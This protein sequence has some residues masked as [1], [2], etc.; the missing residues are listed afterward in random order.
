MPF[1]LAGF[2]IKNILGTGSGPSA[3]A[4]LQEDGF[5]ILQEDGTS[6]ILLE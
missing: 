3:D 5:Y 6:F 4:I 2:S 1:F